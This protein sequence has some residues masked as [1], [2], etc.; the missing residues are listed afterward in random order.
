MSNRPKASMTWGRSLSV[1]G[2]QWQGSGWRIKL[3]PKKWLGA[4]AGTR[5]DGDSFSRKSEIDVGEGI[6]I[7]RKGRVP[8]RGKSWRRPG[9]SFLEAGEHGV[10]A[11]RLEDLMG[12]GT[13]L[14]VVLH[15]LGVGVREEGEV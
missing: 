12:E 1:V 2:L 8:E 5:V 13:G 14:S 11:P 10:E 6:D 9:E 3:W 15:H 7:T 4:K